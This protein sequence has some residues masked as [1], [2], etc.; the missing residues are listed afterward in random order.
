MSKNSINAAAVAAAAALVP[1]AL[2]A[3]GRASEKQ[4][5]PFT[6]RNYAHRGLHT[7]DKSVPENSLEAFKLAAEAGY[8]VELDVQLSRDG[9]VVVFHDSTLDRVC[10]VSAR[11]D[12][13]DY[14]ELKKLSL[15]STD[16]TIPLFTQVL[17]TIGG[18]VPIICEIKTGPENRELCEKTYDIIKKYNG[19]ICIESFD[20][21]IVGWFRF[22]AGD[23]VRGQLSNPPKDSELGKLPAFALGNLLMNFMGRPQFIAYKIGPEPAAVKLCRAMGAMN[24]CWTSRDIKN[25]KGRDCVIFEFY[26]PGVYL[27]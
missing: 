1:L 7:E 14:D 5:A 25:E 2:L 23:L 9:Q 26:R 11:V 12:E 21:R 8:G 24:V 27:E 18:R 3:P 20:P 4:K 17:D 10:G 15:C 19:D 16:Q 6:G 13:M 22:H